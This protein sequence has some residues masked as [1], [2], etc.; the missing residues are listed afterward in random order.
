MRVRDVMT[1]NIA[2]RSPDD[3]LREIARAMVDCDCGIVPIIDSATRKPVGVVTDRDIVCRLVA[4]GRNPIGLKAREV[5]SS[6]VDEISPDTSLEECLQKME[7]HQIRRMLVVD[8]R[9]ACCGIVSQADIARAAPEG[10]TAQ[11][12]KSVSQ[13]SEHASMIR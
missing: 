13:P 7:T 3:D 12:V 2:C 4:S 8:N 6:P 10:E 1:S 5:M 11:L 9:G